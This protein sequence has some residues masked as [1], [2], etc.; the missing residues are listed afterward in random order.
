MDLSTSPPHFPRLPPQAAPG[1]GAHL[2]LPTLPAPSQGLTMPSEWPSA[3]FPWTSA[4]PAT[5][6]K[7][8]LET[9]VEE[10][11]G[12]AAGADAEKQRLEAEN[13]EL[14]TSLLL[15]AEQKEELAQRAERGCRECET[16]WAEPGNPR[17]RCPQPP[18][19]PLV[20]RADLQE[21]GCL[22]GPQGRSVL[23]IPP[24]PGRHPHTH[25]PA[26]T[27]SPRPPPHPHPHPRGQI[28]H[29]GPS[30]GGCHE[31]CVRTHTHTHSSPR[32]QGMDQEHPRTPLQ[33]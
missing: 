7:R 8:A 21:R 17:P 31:P 10:M 15:W 2:T 25:R 16:R 9:A 19:G 3:P 32:G 4:S 27:S 24:M 11:R 30:R 23:Q 22:R 14:H 29:P 28:Y 6:E 13:A 26:P 5:R 33:P 18:T 12:K 1:V 20:S